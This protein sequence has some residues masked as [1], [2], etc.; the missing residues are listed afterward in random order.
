MSTECRIPKAT[1]YAE[2]P[3]GTRPNC[4]P[5]LRF[6]D[7]FKANLLSTGIDP[8]TWEDLA[9][10]R[11]KWQKACSTGV[12]HFED[13]RIAKAEEK[14]SR[15]KGATSKSVHAAE[16]S[17][18]TDPSSVTTAADNLPQELASSVTR[19]FTGSSGRP[20]LIRRPDGRLHHHHFLGVEKYWSPPQ[21]Y[22]TRHYCVNN[23]T[24]TITLPSNVTVG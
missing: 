2:L 14:R 9:C 23:C 3:S 18:S 19:G 7:N 4:H 12:Q 6:K 24:G 8:K 5:L 21:L 20:K 17:D 11:S 16:S 1:F 10:N 13:V 15:R 22:T